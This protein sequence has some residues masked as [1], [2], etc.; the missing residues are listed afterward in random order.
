M[1]ATETHPGGCLCGAVRYEVS[2]PLAP[3]WACHCS[4]CR[5]TSGHYV[6]TTNAKNHVFR[7]LADE[8]L[9]WYASSAEA[10]RGFCRHCGSSLFWRRRGDDYTSIM[11]GTFDGPTGVVVE[12]HIF[13]ADKGDYDSLPDDEPQYPAW[14]KRG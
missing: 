4:Q 3:V 9:S 2:G 10:E 12:G 1:S 14:P 7:I 8:G 13:T 6:A 11:A 5:R